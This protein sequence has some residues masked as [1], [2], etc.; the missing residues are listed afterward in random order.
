MG[1]QC[2]RY[3]HGQSGALQTANVNTSCGYGL[4]AVVRK[5]QGAFSRQG[6]SNSSNNHRHGVAAR[7]QASE[8][9]DAVPS[10]AAVST[11][12]SRWSLSSVHD[13]DILALALPAA[14]ALAADPLLGMVDTALVGR[15]GGDELV[16]DIGTVTA[17]TCIQ[18]QSTW[19]VDVIFQALLPAACH[20][21]ASW[22]SVVFGAQCSSS[23]A[24]LC[25]HQAGL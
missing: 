9:S 20:W 5:A 24:P 4:C 14:L 19:Q 16:S 8:A 18:L 7:V 1:Q 25:Q 2:S 17:A 11:K 10:A 22:H 3:L 15:L 13:R 6:S 12:G 21:G 23:R